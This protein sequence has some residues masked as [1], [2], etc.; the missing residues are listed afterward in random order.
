VRKQEFLQKWKESIRDLKTPFIAMCS[1]N[2]NWGILSSHFPNRT[3]AWGSCCYKKKDQLTHE[4]LN[5]DKTIMMIIN[6]HSN[7][8]HPKVLT[9]LQGFHNF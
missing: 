5:H 6:Q 4:F 2:E 1:L 3:A 7:L 8:S 9:L